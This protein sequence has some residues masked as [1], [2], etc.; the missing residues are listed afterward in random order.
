MNRKERVRQ[1]LLSKFLTLSKLTIP[2]NL[3]LEGAYCVLN[4]V[5]SGDKTA[6]IL[7]QAYIPAIL[8]SSIFQ[9]CD[10]PTKRVS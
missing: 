7:T 8:D 10:I 1:R 4:H 6:F 5:D 9:K 3:S 2:L